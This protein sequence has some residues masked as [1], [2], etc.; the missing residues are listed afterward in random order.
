MWKICGVCP[1]LFIFLPT[2]AVES[3]NIWRKGCLTSHPQDYFPDQNLP[4]KLFSPCRENKCRQVNMEL[5]G[6]LLMLSYEPELLPALF[7]IARSKSIV[8]DFSSIP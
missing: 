5:K 4:T 2:V 1:N 6:I 8:S 7:I 3:S